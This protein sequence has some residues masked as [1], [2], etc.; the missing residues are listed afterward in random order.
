MPFPLQI[1]TGGGCH[2]WMVVGVSGLMVRSGSGSGSRC[3]CWSSC[4]RSVCHTG[5][6]KTLQIESPNLRLVL[7]KIYLIPSPNIYDLKFDLESF[8]LV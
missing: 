7:F 1:L 5:E 8:C 6:R 4:H 3:V 2:G